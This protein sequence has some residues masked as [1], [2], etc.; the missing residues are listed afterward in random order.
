M[1][2]V[3][4]V[5]VGGPGMSAIA[6]VLAHMGKD[7]SGSDI[8]D[9]PV[10]DSL[11]ALGIRINVGHDS[12]V[13]DG[14]D[15]VTFSSAIPTDNIE[16]SAAR[17]RGIEV[18]TRGQML[19][20][21]C[22]KKTSIGV[23]G[24]HGKTTTSSMLMLMLADAGMEPSFIIGGEVVE[25]GTG[26]KW[27]KGS[28]MVVEA[29]ESD[30]THRQLPLAGTILTNIDVDHLD[31]FGS[32]ERIETDFD[33]YLSGISGTRVLCLDD[34]RCAQLSHRHQ[35]TTYGIESAADVRATQILFDHGSSEFDVQVR[36]NG[37]SKYQTLGHIGLPLRG[38]HN[39]LNA[40]GALTMAMELGVSFESAARTLNRFCG[41]A[42]RFDLRGVDAGVT[43]VDDYAH[44]PTE[45]KSVLKGARDA[46]DSWS[47]VV[48]VFQPNRYNRMS[49]LSPSYADAFLGADV[50]VVTEI[51]PSGT[52]PIPG[53]TGKL[54][55]NAVLDS[56][57]QAQ[58]VWLPQ[59]THLVN[60][61]A[62]R[63]RG[64][65]LCVSMGCGDIE[66]LPDEV[67]TR[68]AQLLDAG[69]S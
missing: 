44:L 7:V 32:I 4:V 26:A 56:H 35:S 43:F 13:V 20:D 50:V 18:L 25:V 51:Y 1:S 40:L 11:R 34:A 31:H 64:G 38:Q 30:G 41:V 53:V 29:D 3:H 69:N 62:S 55:V 33:E 60:Y 66:S 63:L 61:L 46:S 37:D 8:R 47:R 42:R 14:C 16:L 39:V 65:D 22:S 21:I 67:I 19:A 36:N 58:V 48:A 28:L 54:V 57:P 24:T 5:G 15:A 6:T 59:R 2:R 23:A 10:L 27:S 12:Q 52:T 49:V 17:Q 45:I 9:S 68:R